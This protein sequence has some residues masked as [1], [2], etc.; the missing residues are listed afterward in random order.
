MGVDVAIHARTSVRALE[1]L[2]L[3]RVLDQL[4]DMLPP[5]VNSI[6]DDANRT[7]Q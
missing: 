6:S 1:E 5:V 4:G 7:R 2:E 3:V